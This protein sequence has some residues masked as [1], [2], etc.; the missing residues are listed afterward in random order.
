M[1]VVAISLKSRMVYLQEKNPCFTLNRKMI[2]IQAG[3]EY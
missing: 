3:L 1:E 2:G